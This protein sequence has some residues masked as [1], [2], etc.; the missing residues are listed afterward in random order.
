MQ[1]GGRLGG[2]GAV[3]DNFKLFEDI[4]YYYKSPYTEPPPWDRAKT[5]WKCDVALTLKKPPSISSETGCSDLS[6]PA[7]S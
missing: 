5:I 6:F 4:M 3:G 2:E 7:G 1:S